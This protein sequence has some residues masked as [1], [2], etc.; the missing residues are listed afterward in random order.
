MNKE[1]PIVSKPEVQETNW[2][3]FL[4][5]LKTSKEQREIPFKESLD[6]SVKT[7]GLPFMLVPL[8]DLHIGAEGTDYDAL[9]RHLD[10]IKKHPI[11]TILLGDLGDFFAPAKHP[12]A[13]LDDVANPTEQFLAIIS[14]LKEYS[15]SILAMVSGNHEQFVK[16]TAGLNLYQIISSQT[17]IPLLRSGGTINLTVD[18]ITYRIKPYHKIAR[19]NSSFNYTHAG[20][21]AVRLSGEEVDLVISGDKHLGAYEQMQYGDGRLTVVQ[22]GTFKIYDEYGHT[23]GFVQKPQVFFPV[24]VFN[25]QKREIITLP[26]IDSGVEYIRLYKQHLRRVAVSMLGVK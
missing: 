26:N 4:S 11:Y 19:Y 12:D 16:K 5:K 7:R 1:A 9:Q 13:M 17:G 6:I 8:S 18:N 21:Q 24:L 20:K 14:F 22:T 23:E 2:S 3:S 10:A 15:G 25:G